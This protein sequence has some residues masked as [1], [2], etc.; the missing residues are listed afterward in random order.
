MEILQGQKT[1]TSVKEVKVATDKRV[2]RYPSLRSFEKNEASVFI[3]RD[4]EKRQLFNKVV[5]ERLVLL[6]ARSGVGKTSLLKAGLIPL[7]EENK[8]YPIE[9]RM[10]DT[11]SAG[12][13]GEELKETPK[14]LFLKGFKRFIDESELKHLQES[15]IFE[16]PEKETKL[17]ELL[18]ASS[19]PLGYTPVFIL[20]Q[21][22]QFF[23]FDRTVQDSFMDELNELIGEEIPIRLQERYLHLD[24][25]Q[26]MD[27]GHLFSQPDIRVIISI[28]ADKIFELNRLSVLVPRLLRSRFELYPLQE[29]EAIRAIVEPA[30]I[31]N[32][33]KFSSRDFSYDPGLLTTIVASLKGD[34]DIIETTQLQILSS[35]IEN[36]IVLRAPAEA[37]NQ[38]TFTVMED[39]VKRIG[40]IDKILDDFYNN[41][42]A[43]IPDDNQRTMSRALIEDDLYGKDSGRKMVYATEINKILDKKRKKIRFRIGFG[44]KASNKQII[45]K[46]IDL[47]LIREDLRDRKKFYEITHDYLLKAIK[48]SADK[49]DFDAKATKWTLIIGASLLVVAVA[50]VFIVNRQFSFYQGKFELLR[51]VYK[52]LGD[53][54]FKARKFDAAFWRYSQAAD[55]G[56]DS[57]AALIDSLIYPTSPGKLIKANKNKNVFLLEAAPE[58]RKLYRS[59]NSAFILYASFNDRLKMKPDSSK[60]EDAV[61]PLVDFSRN[62][63]LIAFASTSD[64]IEVWDLGKLKRENKFAIPNGKILSNLKFSRADKYLLVEFTEGVTLFPLRKT[65]VTQFGKLKIVHPNVAEGSFIDIED[66]DFSYDDRSLAVT[67][68]DEAVTIEVY[69]AFNNGN[70]FV[71]KGESFGEFHPTL[72]LFLYVIGNVEHRI[73]DV[74]NGATTQLGKSLA[75]FSEVLVSKSGR[76]QLLRTFKTRRLAEAPDTVMQTAVY[77]FETRSVHNLPVEII[78]DTVYA[79]LGFVGDCV[80]LQTKS[81][82]TE[83][84]N[85]TFWDPA[86]DSIIKVETRPEPFTLRWLERPVYAIDDK[87]NLITF[88]GKN[89]RTLVDTTPFPN[90]STVYADESEKDFLVQDGNKGYILRPGLNEV[91]PFNINHRVYISG[92]AGNFISLFMLGPMYT[93][94]RLVPPSTLGLKG[95]HKI[96]YYEKVFANSKPKN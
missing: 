86:N 9:I 62:N 84:S 44:V 23:Q 42:L 18:R 24:E 41:Q 50:I 12:D 85:I 59:V 14:T 89:L 74:T 57:A 8:F 15:Q 80:I 96:K 7:L 48:A 75:F 3:G 73:L 78:K 46:L 20:D 83:K 66:F 95:E 88:D 60:N 54:A 1:Q 91:L 93:G 4:R 81:S 31:K 69:G 28:R 82:S 38:E 5:S 49:R 37:Q 35:E 19:I 61:F 47:R 25:T 63:D 53:D 26:Q 56:S 10:N 11:E 30:V 65:E 40:G 55:I 87:G 2:C 6:F 76:Y 92:F 90:T 64:S 43:K 67:K 36:R 21:F 27:Y 33:A 72:P 22:E 52:N 34:N 29:T 45:D 32:P 13:D 70:P 79:A 71:L 58:E 77:D 39:S 16:K 94:T 17:W 51:Q 68:Y